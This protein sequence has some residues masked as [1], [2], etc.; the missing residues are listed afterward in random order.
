MKHLLTLKDYSKEEIES[1]INKAIEIKANPDQ[2]ADV[3][4]NKTLIMLFQKTSTRTRLSF[5]AGMTQLGGH[6]IFLDSRTTQFSFSDFKDEIQAVM[7]FG[8]ILMFRANKFADVELAA[9]LNQKPV[10]DACSEKYHPCQSLGD[11]L[12]MAE[13]AGGLDKIKKVT[14][15]GIENNVSNTLKLVCAKLGIDIAIG[16]PEVDP[17]SVDPELDKMAD[18]SG[19]V[20][21]TT[22]AEEAVKDSQFVHTD[23]WLNMEFFA[24]GKVKPEFKEEFERRVATFKPFQLNAALIDKQ[25][26]QAKIMHCMPCHVG[27]EISRDAIDH[28]NSVIFDQAENR[29]HI[30]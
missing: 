5:E 10:M 23:T 4:K 8:D 28:P 26:P 2:F 25:A 16:A 19:H 30:Q 9:S 11:L 12:T 22:N 24:E 29:M 1:I 20:H 18:D 15:L 14:W 3:L 27:Y 21:K 7:R 17:D 6:A 13:Q